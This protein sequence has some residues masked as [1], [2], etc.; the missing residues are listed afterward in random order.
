MA[1]ASTLMFITAL[2]GGLYVAPLGK[3]GTFIVIGV[4]IFVGVLGLNYITW[5]R[6]LLRMVEQERAESDSE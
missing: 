2:L 5:G 6:P 3:F 1:S 4:L